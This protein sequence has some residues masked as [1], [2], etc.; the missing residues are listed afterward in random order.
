MRKVPPLGL[1]EA[2]D[3]LRSEPK[4]YV[5]GRNAGHDLV[6]FHIARNYGVRTDYCSGADA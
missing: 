1:Q 3:D 5:S 2:L 6:G 4:L